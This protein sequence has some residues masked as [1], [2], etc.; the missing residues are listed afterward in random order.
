MLLET[1]SNKSCHALGSGNGNS[2]LMSGGGAG[3]EQQ[4]LLD[5]DTYH[6]MMSQSQ[7]SPAASIFDGSSNSSDTDSS[8]DDSS[9][10]SSSSSSSQ[11]GMHFF[12]G[13][14]KRLVL[15]L[16]G[17]EKK[18]NGSSNSGNGNTNQ[19]QQLKTTA[20]VGAAVTAS[21]MALSAGESVTLKQQTKHG[22]PMD[23]D[24]DMALYSESGPDL[25]TIPRELWEMML[26][27]VN[28]RI[29]NVISNEHQ[30]AYLL[31]E[32]SMF[33]SK[34]RIIVKT[35]GSTTLLHCLEQIL[36]IVKKAGFETVEDVFYSHKN[37]LVPSLQMHPH[38]SFLKESEFLD[39]AF[40]G[41]SHLFGHVNSDRFYL[42]TLDNNYSLD[43]VNEHFKFEMIMEELDEKVMDLFVR[44]SH[45]GVINEKLT[46]AE[47]TRKAGI[48]KL[49]PGML[50]DDFLF[51]PCGYS[52][53]GLM[54]KH[55]MTIHITPET[56][57][58]YV[59]LEMD[60]PQ[61]HYPAFIRQ[62]LA[63]FK[64]AKFMLNITAPDL[65]QVSARSKARLLSSMTVPDI[66][67]GAKVGDSGS[68][69]GE[70]GNDG[71]EDSGD[72]TPE[73]ATIHGLMVYED[74]L[75]ARFS[76]FR[77]ADL[78]LAHYKHSDIVYARY[79]LE[80]IS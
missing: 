39:K 51:T 61:T 62:V 13:A 11:G 63:T 15:Y 41:L 8:G 7:Q 17:S 29:L 33:V 78:Q 53:N 49:I 70:D 44:P 76:E 32:S 75:E 52:M 18:D 60:V 21:E 35:C 27:V 16:T 23:K 77:R 80:G 58:S 71:K 59:S 6:R 5:Q 24:K 2:L 50:I 73:M 66:N 47:I 54:G 48:D 20:V 9:T 10:A 69:V 72:S 1:V 68:S 12:E 46:G 25:R 19:K 38:H 30:V 31:S 34:N 65:R 79:V 64:P 40:N 3:E 28:C 74:L 4:C 36:E 26:N 14:E 67:K 45:N 37:L 22:L 56:D 55:Y 57:F 43:N 42:Y